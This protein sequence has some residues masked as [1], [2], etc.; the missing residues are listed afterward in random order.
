MKLT[1]NS[2]ARDLFSEDYSCLGDS[3][4]RPIKWLALETLQKKM[5]SEASDTWAF[6]YLSTNTFW[7]V[8]SLCQCDTNV[9]RFLFRSYSVLMW[10]LCTLARQPYQEVVND[11]ME[12]FLSEGYRL[13]QPVNCP[14]EL[15]AI[16]AYCWIL[17]SLERP[18]FG[19]L[20]VCLQ[21][22]HNQL[23]RYI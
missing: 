2:L 22:F 7:I 11:D 19:Q 8:L 4:N 5:F 23:T 13:A 17:S 20:Q 1:D 15:F 9:L 21:D 18:S 14:D 12:Q 3:E 16:M 10:E 6:G